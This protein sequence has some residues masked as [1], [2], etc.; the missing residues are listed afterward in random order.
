VKALCSVI[1]VTVLR[2]SCSSLVGR[3]AIVSCC[4]CQLAADPYPEVLVRSH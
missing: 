2:V 3:P 1:R 4:V